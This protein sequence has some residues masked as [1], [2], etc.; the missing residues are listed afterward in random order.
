MI[1]QPSD[2]LH[3]STHDQVDAAWYASTYP[4][5]VYSGIDPLTHYRQIGRQLGRSGAPP[6]LTKFP[7]SAE[8]LQDTMRGAGLVPDNTRAAIIASGMFD[9][10]WYRS[11]YELAPEEDALANYLAAHEAHPERDPGPL[12]STHLYR[13]LHTDTS[14]IHPLIHYAEFGI[15][16]ARVAICPDKADAFCGASS[17]DSLTPLSKMFRRSLPITVLHWA[18]GNFF[19]TEIAQY[20]AAFLENLGYTTDLRTNDVGL[21]CAAHQFLVVA[22]H[23]YNVYGP[24]NGW[25]AEKC[26]KTV[27]L[28]TEQW[29]TS[30]FALALRSIRH[31]NRALDINPRSAAAMTRLGIEASFIPLLPLKGSC[32]DH[33]RLP[34]STSVMQGKAI[35]AL[36]YPATFAA[37]RYDI[38]FVAALNERRSRALAELAPLLAELDC[39]L[40]CPVFQGPVLVDSADTLS[41][42]DFVQISRNSKILLNIHQGESRY[43]EWHRIFLS[44][45]MEGCVVVTEPCEQ[46]GLLTPNVHYIEVP[47]ADMS[48]VLAELLQTEEGRQRLEVI[49]SNCVKLRYQIDLGARFELP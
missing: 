24:G 48:R 12:F 22:P 39:Y 15:G 43:F 11:R 32:F 5:V 18:L 7:N 9:E 4:D 29:Q 25:S 47:L 21:D 41:G 36:T 40:H 34:L 28:N 31:S 27:Y 1:T 3:C 19:F 26:R 45:I 30:W 14:A 13:N 6:A 16:E 8:Q 20:I 37:R 17:F 42:S 33:G 49:H 10:A 23:E 44:G 35:H 38:L 46:V 2:S